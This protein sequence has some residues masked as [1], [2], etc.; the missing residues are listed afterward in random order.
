[1]GA[2]EE[3]PFRRSAVLDS[4]LAEIATCRGPP[5]RR[6]GASLLPVRR[7][8]QCLFAIRERLAQCRASGRPQCRH[9][10][11]PKQPKSKPHT[12]RRVP[13]PKPPRSNPHRE[14]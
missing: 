8:M 7:E 10:P 12:A 3:G 6:E 9:W 11:K 5:G 14:K 4:P 1:K 2:R 13:P